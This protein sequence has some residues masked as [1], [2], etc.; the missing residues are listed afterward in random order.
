MLLIPLI[1]VLP[2]FLSDKVEAVFLAE[3]I[4]DAIAVLTTVTLFRREFKKILKSMEH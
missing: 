3:P 2:L 4:A 1:F